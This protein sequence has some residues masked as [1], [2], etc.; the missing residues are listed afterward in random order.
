MFYRSG[1]H[2]ERLYP[3]R[4]VQDENQRAGGRVSR[5]CEEFPHRSQGLAE[6]GNLQNE[7]EAV[8]PRPLVARA[9]G[10]GLLPF[11]R[12][13]PR[14]HASRLLELLRRKTYAVRAGKSL[15]ERDSRVL[16]LAGWADR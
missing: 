2:Q 12:H 10:V 4:I 1:Y 8:A 9:R 3:S 7:R 14:P 6:R 16:S 13:R 5:G 11:C 15:P